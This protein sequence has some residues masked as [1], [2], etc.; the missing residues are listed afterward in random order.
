MTARFPLILCFI[1]SLS[2]AQQAT[3]RPS[4]HENL[5]ALLWMQ[6]S[7]E[8]EAITL[9]TFQTAHRQLRRALRE[10]HW[11]AAPEQ[12]GAF[13]DLPPAIILDL[14]ET[15]LDNSSFMA[16]LVKEG[17][18]F[19]EQEWQKWVEQERALPIPGALEFLHE[20][21]AHGVTVFYVTNRVCDVSNPSDHTV[22]VLK[23]LQFPFEP[24]QL[25]CR[26]TESSD[27]S[28]RRAKVA[29]THRVLMLFGDDFNDFVT[30][31]K[32]KDDWQAAVTRRKTTVEAYRTFWGTRWFVLPNPTYGSWER[33]IGGT[34]P[35]K[36]D[37][38]RP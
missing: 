30:V 16:K 21:Q 31:P 7:A 10:K 32:A 9:Q 29:A 18:S 14:D 5:N 33:T 4:P 11:T 24:S 27:K 22:A 38:L 25:L 6:R 26:A 17:R 13:A 28:P 34:I 8:Y 12:K 1:T 20:A 2:F 36:I 35:A 19:S 3:Q 37:A 15:V 23:A